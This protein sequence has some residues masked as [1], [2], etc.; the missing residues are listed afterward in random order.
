MTP[1]TP[2]PTPPTSADS[3]SFNT[4]ADNF[5]SALP[6]F[7]DELNEFGKK[8]ESQTSE[9]VS[10]T[11][12]DNI[13]ARLDENEARLKKELVAEVAT[14]TSGLKRASVRLLDVP[15]ITTGTDSTPADE[16]LVP[17]QLVTRQNDTEHDSEIVEYG[18]VIVPIYNVNSP[19]NFE[20]MTRLPLP[21]TLKDFEN[22]E[23]NTTENRGKGFNGTQYY[24]SAEHIEGAETIELTEGD[25]YKRSFEFV[26][27]LAVSAVAGLCTYKLDTDKKTAEFTYQAP[28]LNE[29]R[30]DVI[31]LTINGVATS[32]N[33]SIKKRI[34][35]FS[36]EELKTPLQFKH[37]QSNGRAFLCHCDELKDSVLLFGNTFHLQC[38]FRDYPTFN[39]NAIYSGIKFTFPVAVKKIFCKAVPMVLCEDG[40]VWVMG[41]Q[42]NGECGVGNTAELKRFIKNPNLHNIKDLFMSEANFFALTNDNKLYAWGL[43]TSG[44]LGLKNANKQLAPVVVDMEF[45]SGV[46]DIGVGTNF[47]HILLENGKVL[48]SGAQAVNSTKIYPASNQFVVMEYQ[49]VDY[50]NKESLKYDKYKRIWTN[51]YSTEII[52]ASLPYENIKSIWV[53]GQCFA[54]QSEDGE[55]C[56]C[57]GDSYSYSIQMLGDANF[58]AP[59]PSLKCKHLFGDNV[60]VHLVACNQTHRGCLVWRKKNDTRLFALSWG[61][62]NPIRQVVGELGGGDLGWDAQFCHTGFATEN[63]LQMRCIGYKTNLF[64]MYWV[65]KNKECGKDDLYHWVS[66]KGFIKIAY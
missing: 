23:N 8:V 7:A 31:T 36:E 46:K 34:H 3:A 41:Q 40:S 57:T 51:S 11:I 9:L 55:L 6:L 66:G 56:F 19:F 60:D 43:N 10:T 15:H 45:E 22:W 26:N 1:I 62:G 54:M 53:A 50:K 59:F 38:D 14:Q 33:V 12:S 25:S 24:L 44:M 20:K 4:R 32:I 42:A 29:D 47:T 52:G 39:Q 5:L 35:S 58:Y 64:D 18:D 65:L 27:T 48:R 28:L 17:F 63:C 61:F 21:K 30:D 16:S 49:R 37:I 2:L 13:N